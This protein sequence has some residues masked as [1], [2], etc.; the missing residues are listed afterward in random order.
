M[1]YANPKVVGGHPRKHSGK[2]NH[3]IRRVVIHSAVMPC[4]PGRARQ[5]A[6]MNSRG[7]GGGSW[8]YATD[9]T[10]TLQC[11]YDSYVCWH[12]PPNSHSIGIEMADY[13]RPWPPGAHTTAWWNKL[14]ST[15]RW[16]KR[17]QKLMLRRTARLTAELLLDYDLPAVFLSP[18]DLR[19]GKHGVTTHANVSIA[20]HQSSHWD[21]G[22]WPRRRFMYLVRRYEARLKKR[23]PQ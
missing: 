12:A 10:E 22:A 18:E 8:H 9:P 21:P 3:P 4:E 1:V 14:R 16:G 15:W 11:S 7:S 2:G 17:N 13:P 6:A 20:F 23:G 5:L 19:A